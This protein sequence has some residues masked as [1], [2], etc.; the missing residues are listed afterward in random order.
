MGNLSQGLHY[1]LDRKTYDGLRD[2]RTV[3]IVLVVLE[4]PENEA[5]WIDCTLDC[6]IMR[7]CAWWEW[8][9]LAGDIAT[10]SKIIIIP[11]SQRFDLG[12][13]QGMIRRIREGL[14]VNEQR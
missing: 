9:G 13:L 14:P 3:P 7:R 1:A 5:D 12:A 6:L 8:L 2:E 10:D 11:D 4:L